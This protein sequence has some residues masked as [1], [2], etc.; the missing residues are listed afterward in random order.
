MELACG[1]Q[2]ERWRDVVL[3]VHCARYIIM[4][5]MNCI[6]ARMML[7][8]FP[9]RMLVAMALSGS[10]YTVGVPIFLS[11]NLEYRL[12]LWHAL[13]FVASLG[14]YLCN[15]FYLVGGSPIGAP[16]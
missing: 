15:Y 4:G 1:E 2:G 12:A 5:W 10:L 16:P 13:V 3:N 14:F 9:S 7:D 11:R 8:M 6:N